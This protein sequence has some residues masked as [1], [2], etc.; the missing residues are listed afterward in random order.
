MRKIQRALI[1]VHDKSGILPLAKALL[2]AG[3]EIISTGGTARFLR[4]SG[5]AVTSLEKLIDF[6]EILDG[7]VKTLHPK[8]FGGILARRDDAKHLE[9]LQQNNIGSI[10]L[11]V[12]NLYP[13]V[14]T[15]HRADATFDE[16]IENID[17]GGV[18]LIRAAAKNFA[19]V[20]VVT[21]FHQYQEVM[22]D[23]KVNSGS[24]SKAMRQKLAIDAFRH[25]A[26][27]DSAIY[28]YL[29][30]LQEVERDMPPA[31]L[32]DLE[33]VQNLRYGENP[34]QPAALYR[35]QLS[36]TPG[37][38]GAKVLQGKELSYNNFA[39]L[40]AVFCLLQDF[41]EPCTVIVKHANPCG[42]AIGKTLYDSYHAAKQTDPVS[43]FGGIVGFNREVDG[44]TA[45]AVSELFTECILAPGFD[46][47]AREIFSSKKNLRLLES[48]EINRPLQASY[49]FKRIYGG[50]LVQRQDFREDDQSQ[51]KIVTRRSPTQEEWAALLFAWKVVRSVK[52]NAIVYATADRTIGI[53]AGQMSR[54]DASLLAVEKAHRAGLSIAGTAMASDAFFPFPDGVEAAAKAGATAVIQP[55]GSV[56]DE[57]VVATADAHNLAMVFTG[58]R[59]FRH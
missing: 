23:F 7:R 52:S 31:L 49:D 58:V 57:Q 56:R 10:D 17:V 46:A 47:N 21:D 51:F 55:G 20:A 40:D 8:I 13:F 37:L 4:D 48:D 36:P 3:V 53:G 42:V 25:T 11:V 18:A 44:K 34:H 28:S 59:H 38:L 15:A 29:L 32:I 9:Q 33:K 30:K 2:K 41:D 24:L 26:K 22:V 14:E 50:M 35:D 27:Y 16:C 45:E 19:D 5:L 39:D 12:I 43:A 6:P 1:S 54:V